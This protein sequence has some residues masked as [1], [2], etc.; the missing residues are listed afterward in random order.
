MKVCSRHPRYKGK[1]KP[2]VECWDCAEIWVVMS[3]QL[4]P[5][6]KPNQVHKDKK[7]YN[8]KTKGPTDE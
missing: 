1:S 7:K 8:R 3:T 2:K 5:V 4:K 6:S